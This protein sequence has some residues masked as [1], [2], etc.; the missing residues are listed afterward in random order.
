MKPDRHEPIKAPLW[1]QLGW[2]VIIWVASV[3][4][5]GAVALLIRIWLRS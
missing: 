4:V 5:L 2:L 3:A 1:Q